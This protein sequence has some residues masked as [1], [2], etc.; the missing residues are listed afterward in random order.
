MYLTKEEERIL[1]GEYGEGMRKALEIL[2]AIGKIYDADKLIPISSAH[3]SGVSYNNIGEAGLMFLRD[4]SLETKVSVRTT[5]NP[6]GMD[7]YRWREIKINEEFARKQDE[8]IKIFEKMGIEITLSCI[9]YLI[10]NTPN[11]GDHVAWSESSAVTYINSVVGAMTNRESG[12]SALAAGIIGKTPRYGMHIKEER[13]PTIRVKLNIDINGTSDFGALGYIL[14]KRVNHEI[15][16]IEGIKKTSIDELIAFSA[17]TATYAGLPIFHIP[18]VTAEWRGFEAPKEVI[19]IDD[20]DMKEAYEYLRD[21]FNNVDLVWIGCPHT[22][23]DELKKIANLLKNKT[24]STEF[25]ITTTR[26]IRDEAEKQ[27]YIRTIEDAGAKVICDTCVVVMPLRGRFK[28][29]V[30]TSAKACYYCRG[31][32]KFMVK[33]ASLEKCVDTAIKGVWE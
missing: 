8:V 32:N 10:G 13:K 20:K 24:V 27:G 21:S 6:G 23:I 15:P 19:E 2:L 26:K 30:T 4:F 9:P 1:A 25:W 5:L 7:L 28:T 33:V 3:V 11:K 14:Y 18:G 17:S 22:T 16:W 12:I 29:L 31:I